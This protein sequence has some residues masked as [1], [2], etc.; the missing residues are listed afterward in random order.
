MY[1]G[2]IVELAKTEELFDNPQHPYTQALLSAIAV[3]DPAI[4]RKNRIILEGDVPTPINPPSG[5]RFHTRCRYKMDIC[6]KVDPEF[7]DTGGEHFVACHLMD[8]PE[9]NQPVP[10]IIMT[11]E[12]KQPSA[13]VTVP[14]SNGPVLNRNLW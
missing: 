14:S 11:P 10:V 12:N 6:E 1:L 13:T 4:K 3:P 9:K 7:K 5:C 2:K 8:M